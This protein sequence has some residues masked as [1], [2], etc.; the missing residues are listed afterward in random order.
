[1][2][3]GKAKELICRTHG[4]ELRGLMLERGG[5]RAEGDKWEKKME[6]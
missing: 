3:N 4:H 5:C 6:L 2:G 1:M